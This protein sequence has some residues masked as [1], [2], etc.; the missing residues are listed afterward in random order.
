[1]TIS[2]TTR[3][4]QYNGDNS[5]TVFAYDFNIQADS[6]I[7]VYLGT[8]VGAPT[9]W[10]KKTLTTHYTVSNAGV[11]GG[12]NI[13]FTSGNTP[14]SGTGNVFIRRVTPKTQATDFV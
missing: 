2:T 11:A 5:T 14:P 8:P 6:E 3:T 13:T 4:K 12:G 10:T 1:M 7:E 9:T